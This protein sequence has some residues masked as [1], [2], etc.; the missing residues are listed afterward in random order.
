MS[1][2]PLKLYIGCIA[3]NGCS[4][5]WALILYSP[6]KKSCTFY[7][8][9]EDALAPTLTN[10][11]Q[12]DIDPKTYI[13][14]SEKE[15]CSIAASDKAEVDHAAQILVPETAKKYIVDMLVLLERK[16]VVPWGT[17]ARCE[18]HIVPVEE[19]V[20]FS[21]SSDSGSDDGYVSFAEGEEG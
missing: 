12:S 9:R 21:C 19:T 8:A 17:T 14:W 3:R 20:F 16:N 15:V 18:E 1:L 7:Y 6:D 13:V 5:Q 4:E 2:D 11:K 10:V